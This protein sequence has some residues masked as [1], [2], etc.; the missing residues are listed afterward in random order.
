[1]AASD[2]NPRYLAYCR[3][4]GCAAPEAM[5]A[6]DEERYPGGRMAGFMLWIGERWRAW[7][8][9]V[10]LGRDAI[11][12]EAEHAAFDRWIGAAS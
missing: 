3:A 2:V 4:Q 12:G 1:M 10:G 7:K 11:L 5:L 8:Q 6:L 9:A